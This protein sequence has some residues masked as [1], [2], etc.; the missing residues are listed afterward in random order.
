VKQ[1]RMKNYRNDT[2]TCRIRS[3]FE[4]MFQNCYPDVSVSVYANEI[5]EESDFGEV[6]DCYHFILFFFFL[7][8][9]IYFC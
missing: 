7:C 2:N 5:F 4:P 8:I 9:Y 1:T 6:T 3:E